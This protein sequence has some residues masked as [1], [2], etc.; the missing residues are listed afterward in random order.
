VQKLSGAV[1]CTQ[2]RR[3]AEIERSGFLHTP[4]SGKT[5]GIASNQWRI[6]IMPDFDLSVQIGVCG[7]P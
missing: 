1:F 2:L 5:D 6:D 4:G 7:F 3:S